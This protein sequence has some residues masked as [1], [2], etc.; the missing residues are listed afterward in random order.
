MSTEKWVIGTGFSRGIGFELAKIIKDNNFKII[1]LGRGQCGFEDIF[2]WWDLLNP[3]KESPILELSKSLYGKQVAG[4][5]YAAGVMPILAVS[6]SNRAE[7]HLF[8]QSQAEALRVNYLSCAEII[9][10]ILPFIMSKNDSE[11]SITPFVAHLSSLAAIDPFPGLELYGGT[12][13]ACLHYFKWLS[14]RF[15]M[16]EL[17]CLSVHPGTVNTD[18]VNNILRDSSSDLGVVNLFKKMQQNNEFTQPAK[19][20]EKIYKFLFTDSDLRN[21]AHGKL[22]LADKGEIFAQK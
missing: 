11:A 9:E 20:A 17:T 21:N 2:V 8:W 6:E 4:F 16:D 13:A 12:K 3:I 10:D 7:K 22:F 15:A 14:R 18:M 1:H 19:A 5:I